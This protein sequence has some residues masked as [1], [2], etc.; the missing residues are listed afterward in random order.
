MRTW[1]L[2][3]LAALATILTLA[4][5]VTTAAS[6]RTAGA[7]PTTDQLARQFEAVAFQD[8]F[9]GRETPLRRWRERPSLAVFGGHGDIAAQRD[10]LVAVGNALARAVPRLEWTAAAAPATATLKFGIG[11]RAAM[12]AAV[13][14]AGAMAASFGDSVCIARYWLEPGGEHIA[15]AAVI[16][17]R[18]LRPSLMAHCIAEELVQVM[19]L[20]NDACHY[21]PS[22]FCE[23]DEEPAMTPAD[24]I[25]LRTLYDDRLRTGMSRAEAMPIARAIIAELWK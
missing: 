11:S 20:P 12:L 4:G 7:R 10:R 9:S 16:V 6:E 17:D 18:D 2:K 13:G 14:G 1:T 5:C 3:T 8:E 24:E 15:R 23:A 19:G 22:L 21:R 25:L